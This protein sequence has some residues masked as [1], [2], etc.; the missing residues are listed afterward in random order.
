MRLMSPMTF[1]VVVA[2]A[3]FLLVGVVMV[4]RSLS[5]R[6]SQVTRCSR[7]GHD[8]PASAKFCALCGAPIE[9]A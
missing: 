5:Q 8:N 6:L 1:I 9:G 4:L 3:A 7:C 2:L